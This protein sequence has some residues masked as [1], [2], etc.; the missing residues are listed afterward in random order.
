VRVRYL[1]LLPAGLADVDKHTADGLLRGTSGSHEPR[2]AA[3]TAERF[4]QRPI[5]GPCGGSTMLVV[6]GASG[7]GRLAEAQWP[8]RPRR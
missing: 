6:Y 8:G 7:N 4:G 3:G 5:P 1:G 2:T